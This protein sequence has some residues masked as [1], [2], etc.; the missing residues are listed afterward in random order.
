MRGYVTPPATHEIIRDNN[1]YGPPP[2]Q[3]ARLRELPHVRVLVR[4]FLTDF[5]VEQP[6]YFI[7]FAGQGP[8]IP[9][10]SRAPAPQLLV[11]YRV[12]YDESAAP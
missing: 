9:E 4:C 6:Q 10:Q 2:P 7:D 5:D 8:H 12:R 11:H 1:W 3:R